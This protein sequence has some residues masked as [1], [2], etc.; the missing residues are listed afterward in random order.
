MNEVSLTDLIRLVHQFAAKSWLPA[1]SGNFS[2]RTKG[3]YPVQITAT[4]SNKERLQDS[5]FLYV[6]Y[7]GK[8]DPSLNT[9]ARASAETKIH[10]M[11]YQMFPDTCVVLHV[12]SPAV[13]TLSK[14]LH[15]QGF[16]QIDINGYELQKAYKACNS[17]DDL[18]TVPIIPNS[19][20]MN[21]LTNEI[22]DK[23]NPESECFILAGHGLYTWS[24]TLEQAAAVTEATEALC[25]YKHQELIAEK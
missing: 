4:G 12:H 10:C 16:H 11:L 22:K 20:D 14:L 7:N 9:T 23:L 5:D 3:E 6:D 21:L 25:S 15:Q 19:Q 17:H 8:I 2:R 1:T 24:D 13:V 18:L